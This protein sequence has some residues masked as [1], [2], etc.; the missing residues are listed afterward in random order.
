MLLSRVLG[1]S[2]SADLPGG[3]LRLPPTP[4]GISPPWALTVALTAGSQESLRKGFLC[5][6]LRNGLLTKTFWDYFLK[7][8][9]NHSIF[10][11]VKKWAE[12]KRVPAV[13]R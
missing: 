12:P 7:N 6:D 11:K 9:I 4:L 2:P 1:S 13:T 8:D 10:F 3:V 5:L